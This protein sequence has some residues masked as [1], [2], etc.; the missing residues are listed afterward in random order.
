[1]TLETT[2]YYATNRKGS[3][4]EPLDGN[5]QK[6]AITVARQ[7][8]YGPFRNEKLTYG[9]YT[10]V[11]GEPVLEKL[12]GC[13]EVPLTED[14]DVLVFVHG[15]NS[16]FARYTKVVAKLAESIKSD[17]GT[18]TSQRQIAKSTVPQNLITILYSWPS[19]GS[20]FAYMQD[21]CS[22]QY[23]YPHF[24]QFIAEIT[25]LVGSTSRIHFVAHSLGCQLVYRYLL[26]R[27]FTPLN[28]SL[29]TKAAGTVIFSCPDLD[30][31]TVA[32][33]SERD[34]LSRSMDRG[35]ILVSDVDGP[36]ELSRALH[37]YTRLGRP[38]LSS[39]RSLF[40]GTFRT[41]SIP[42]I[43]STVVHMPEIIVRRTIKRINCGLRNP[44]KIW[45]ETNKDKGVQFADNIT[46]YDFTIADRRQRRIGHSI[47]IELIASLFN[48]GCAPKDW[49][50]EAIVKVPD[51]FV[52]CLVIPYVRSQP[53]EADDHKLFIYKKLTPPK[54]N[55]R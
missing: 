50:E 10:L 12:T 48:N 54:A 28:S 14:T 17:L 26:D 11:E 37:G 33:D 45:Q 13:A 41:G 7:R 4:D 6:G 9:R 40:W 34:M 24:K 35:F 30:Y 52:E 53:Y 29:S 27:S 19:M 44:D 18:R 8:Y 47:C 3:K 15:F 32:L 39:A 20:P 51:E 23:S 46:L 42:N 55:R 36:L 31:Q 22:V 25:A 5:G 21:E 38:A 2:I 1:M 43:V 49:T 16:P